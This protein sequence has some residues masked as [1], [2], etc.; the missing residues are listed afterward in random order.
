MKM[1]GGCF[2]GQVRYAVDIDNHQAYL[3]HCR[4]CQRASGNVSIAFKQVKQAAVN[5]LTPPRWFA[6]SAIAKRAFCPNCGTHL[7]FKYDE[8]KHLDLTVASFDQPEMFYPVSN[9]GVE[10]RLSHWHDCTD[11]PDERADKW[12]ALQARWEQADKRD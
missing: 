7:A 6:S 10:S 1:S 9:F 8:G 2:C 12:P 4:M 3:C 11:L 5:W